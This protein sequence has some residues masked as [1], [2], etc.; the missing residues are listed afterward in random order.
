MTAK[1]QGCQKILML[2]SK[3]TNMKQGEKA[4]EL[5]IEKIQSWVIKVK[6]M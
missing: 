4:E 6:A 1:K 2:R 3:R 5:I